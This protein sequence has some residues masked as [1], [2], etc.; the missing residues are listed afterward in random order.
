MVVVFFGTPAFAVPTLQALLTSAHTVAAVVTQPD[1]PKGRGQKM[2]ASPVKVAAGQTLILQPE[3]A[4]T[5]DFARQLEAFHADIG[6]VAAYGQIL[7]QPILDTPRLGMINVHASLLPRYRGAAPVQRAIINGDTETGVT[8]MRMVRALDA[9]PMI[10]TGRV[11]IGPEQ[12][13]IEIEDALAREGATLLMDVLDRLGSLPEIP[14]DDSLATYAPKI[15][16]DDGR[17]DWSWPAAR[18][19]NVIRALHPWPHAVTFADGRRLILHR[20]RPSPDR[21][22]KP[23]GTVLAAGA[24]GIHVAT[25]DGTLDLIELQAEGG[26]P[27]PAR[28][29]L[30]GHPLVPGTV[31]RPQ[32]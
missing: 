10:A 16:K 26:R 17:V 23:A 7:S 31:L 4:K 22:D 30:A 12:T 19:H 6:I 14:Q 3:S 1:R 18:I 32:A 27:L 20:S 28:D 25:G 24:D 15:V 2:T 29:F 8:I 9:G 11:H 21:S 5:E 13:N